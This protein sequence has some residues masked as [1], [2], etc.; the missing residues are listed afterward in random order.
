MEFPSIHLGGSGKVNLYN[1]SA[2]VVNALDIAIQK[3]NDASP[4]MRDYIN[5]PSAYDQ[6]CRDNA[7]RV[8]SLRAIQNE[9]GNI[10]NYCDS[11]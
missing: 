5:R 1:Q 8:L 9:F 6:A 3:L 2:E 7:A 10:M 4:H 11:F